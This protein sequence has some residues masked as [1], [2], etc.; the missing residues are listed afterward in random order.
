MPAAFSPRPGSAGNCRPMCPDAAAITEDA[1][2]GGRL[3]LKQPRR[4]HRFGHD[5]VLLA[6]AVT[7]R[8]GER[9]VELGSGVGAASLALL[10]RL[11]GIDVTLVEI[12]PALVALAEQN[13]AANG[14]AG[15]AR[16]VVA[17]VA[18]PARRLAALGLAP[19]TVDHVLMNPPFNV[20][21]PASPDAARRRA[22]EAGTETL[23]VWVRTA[24][25]LLRGGGTLTL[26]ARAEQL[27]E[28]L[29]ALARGYGAIAIRPV[30][31]QAEQ[32]AIRV[33]VR[34]VKGSRAPLSLWPPLSLNDASGRPTPEAEAILREGR[35][36]SFG[37]AVTSPAAVADFAATDRRKR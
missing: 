28:I 27:A 8:P 17:D 1:V 11:P 13:I 26:I 7:A 19:D 2:L 29:T 35:A 4:G 21:K 30:L 37:A 12:D 6:A 36:L 5:A 31:P 9:A 14:F 22:H 15:R 34:A 24:T 10:A 16:A 25:R 20:G 32:P 18:A 3:R 33:L 23:A